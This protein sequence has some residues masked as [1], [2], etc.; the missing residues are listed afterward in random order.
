[1]LIFVKEKRILLEKIW[2]RKCNWLKYI[3]RGERVLN[4]NTVTL[5]ETV[6]RE[7]KE[8]K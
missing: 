1:M 5:K 7:V 6:E 2:R 4:E 8:G 3:L